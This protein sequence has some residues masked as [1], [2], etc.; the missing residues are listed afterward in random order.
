LLLL[1]LLLNRNKLGGCHTLKKKRKKKKKK[2][3][4]EKKQEELKKRGESDAPL[5]LG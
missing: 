3:E 2:K 5:E 1:D 4:G